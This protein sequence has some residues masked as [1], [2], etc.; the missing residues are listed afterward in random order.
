VVGPPGKPLEVQ[1]RSREMHRRA[2]FGIAAH[3]GYKENASASDVAWLQRIVD[4]QSETSDPA[5]FMESLKLDLES[6]EVYVFTPKGDVISLP[7]GSTPIDFAYAVHTEVGHR[8]IGAKVNGRLVS[9]DVVL[10]SGD[11]VEVFTAKV[12]SAGPSRDWLQIVASPRARNKI[13]QWFSRERR[14]D[15]IENGREELTKAIRREGLPVQKVASSHVLVKLAETMNY[16]DLEALHAAIG[17]G[18]VSAKSVGQRLARE[19]RGGE[20]EV[21]LPTTARQP[22]RRRQTAGVFVEGF[23]DMMV[24]LSKC[25]TPVPGDEILGYVTRGRG[26]SVHRADCTNAANLLASGGGRL[27]EVEWD[28]DRTGFFVC[29][30]EVKALDRTRLLT[31]VTR[32]LSEHHVNI[33]ASSTQTKRDASS[34][35]RFDFE[36]ADPAHLDSL[37]SA[38]KRVDSVYD[39][40][41]VLPGKG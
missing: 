27:I 29:S 31:D 5:E 24:R 32:V 13:R 2:E 36:L 14:E 21:Q 37:L 22:H 41:R 33:L 7:V 25:C 28:R 4:W 8:C 26:V 17:D 6:D 11:A 16:A 30:V 19:L 40:Y 1:I 15:A 9:L 39:A 35:M 18:H 38:L 34:R 12:P 3:W 23:D 10:H 20:H